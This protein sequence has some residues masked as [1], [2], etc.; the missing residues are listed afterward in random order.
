MEFFSFYKSQIS[1]P[2][3]F[4]STC[5]FKGVLFLSKSGKWLINSL[6]AFDFKWHVLGLE[7]YYVILSIFPTASC[8]MLFIP[9]VPFVPYI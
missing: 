7:K 6:S 2:H 3:T 1:G 4:Y 8:I 5:F 9:S